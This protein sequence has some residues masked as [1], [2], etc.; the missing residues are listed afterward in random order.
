ME[1]AF[2]TYEGPPHVGAMRVA[3]AM[4]GL[5]YVL[6]APHGDT[7]ADLLFTMIERRDARS[8]HGNHTSRRLQRQ[9]RGNA[10]R[11]VGQHQA[12]RIATRSDF[13]EL[14]GKR[15][16]TCE[17]TAIGQPVARH[18][19]DLRVLH[20]REVADAVALRLQVVPCGVALA[21]GRELLGRG[22]GG[23]G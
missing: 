23:N 13:D 7:Y 17:D 6:H 4:E 5:H 2:W 12:D 15:P 9:K 11:R 14:A 1:L 19:L 16:R 8:H 3:A 22:V 20:A 18:V 10:L 21:L